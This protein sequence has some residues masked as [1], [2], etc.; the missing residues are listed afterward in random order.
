MLSWFVDSC[1]EPGEEESMFMEIEKHGGNFRWRFI[2][3]IFFYKFTFYDFYCSVCVE[4]RLRQYL[5]ISA[6]TFNATSIPWFYWLI[7]MLRVFPNFTDLFQCPLS[8]SFCLRPHFPLLEWL[9]LIKW[10]NFCWLPSPDS[11]VFAQKIHKG[12]KFRS[13]SSKYKK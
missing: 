4:E 1:P 10:L 8:L 2:F 11:Q 13:C 7:S 12:T 6:S 5:I 9:F 3:I